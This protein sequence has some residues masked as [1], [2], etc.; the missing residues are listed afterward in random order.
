[1]PDTHEARC[2]ECGATLDDG[3]VGYFSGIMWHEKQPT[4]WQRLF[5]FVLSTGR[6]VIG[7]WGSTPWT[8]CREARK[9]R[10]C[11]TLVLPT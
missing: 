10:G 8:R 4:G 1:M 6:F 2:P 5:P 7:N 3:F 11:G 9:C